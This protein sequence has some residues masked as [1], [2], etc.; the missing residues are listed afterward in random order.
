MTQAE[1]DYEFACR[2]DE[3]E[4]EYVSISATFLESF[5]YSFNDWYNDNDN[6]AIIFVLS[7]L[8]GDTNGYF[9]I[10]DCDYSTVK[11]AKNKEEGYLEV[12]TE[13]DGGIL[14]YRFWPESET[15]KY[16]L[17]DPGVSLEEYLEILKEGGLVDDYKTIPSSNISNVVEMINDI[18]ES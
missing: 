17:G 15:A 12:Y 7:Q 14:G 18:L 1:E 6:A 11:I 13:C 3:I 4:L 9:D 5:D 8:Y 10:S 16:C 2:L